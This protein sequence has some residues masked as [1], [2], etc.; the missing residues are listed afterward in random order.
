LLNNDNILH[1]GQ[2]VEKTKHV[3]NKDLEDMETSPAALGK[4]I[5]IEECHVVGDNVLPT[6][7]A[8]SLYNQRHVQ[9]GENR[10]S[11]HCDVLSSRMDGV[12]VKVHA[13]VPGVGSI[14]MHDPP[15]VGLQEVA[16]FLVASALVW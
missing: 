10:A 14:K 7:S 3:S 5:S 8:F 13:L 9:S 6:N 2:Q 12:H 4:A 11:T 15:L 1:G 16:A